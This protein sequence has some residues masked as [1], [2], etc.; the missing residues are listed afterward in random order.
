MIIINPLIINTLFFGRIPV[1]KLRSE[2]KSEASFCEPGRAF[3]YVSAPF[4]SST[5]H[6]TRFNP[7]RTFRP[8]ISTSN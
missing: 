4:R 2:E 3:R 5:L 7:L 6:V 8:S 1:A